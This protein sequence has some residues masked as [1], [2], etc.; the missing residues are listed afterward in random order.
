MKPPAAMI[1]TSTSA[2]QAGTSSEVGIAPVCPPPS[3]PCTMTTSA[4]SSTAFSTWRGAPQV[5]MQSTPASLRRPI[6]F[7][8]GARL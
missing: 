2:A 8:S 1:G 6:S 4:P 7:R 5:G 3:A